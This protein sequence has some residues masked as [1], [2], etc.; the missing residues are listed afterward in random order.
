MIEPQEHDAAVEVGVAAFRA[1][2]EPP[3]DEQVRQR[4]AGAGV[5]PWLAER[6]L[7]FL[8]VAYTRRLLSDVSFTGTLLAPGGRVHLAEEP[9]FAA[10]LAR[11]Q[12]AGR[13]EIERIALRSGEFDAINNA[14][15]S[16][17]K[18]ADLELGE[19]TL[20]GDLPPAGPGDGGVP[21][22]RAAFQELLREHGVADRTG[23]D[24]RIFPHPAPPGV[25]MAQVDFTVTHP[26]LAGPRLV[27]SFAGHGPT[28]RD[29]LGRA[30][31]LFAGGA[32]HPI[33]DGLLRPGAAAGQVTRERYDHPD[34]PFDLV[35]GPWITLFTD[36]EVPGTRALLDQLLAALRAEPLTRQV[37]ALRLFSAHH[38]GR[39]QSSEVLVDSEPWAAG[40]ALVASQAA[41][42][43]GRVAV[44]V[45]G[46]L[47]PVPGH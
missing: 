29:A 8:P 19:P 26:A 13:G 33:V 10:A 46:L 9:V 45:F 20:T 14:L 37:H 42:L 21:S 17:S 41:P 11:A 30:L 2:D 22:P 35:L 3:S 7:L 40:E 36:E 16:G 6:L 24:A 38:D 4:L 43:P 5:E 1:G 23:A 12:R 32:L 34:G 15:Q 25:V 47:V 31:N 18:L 39:L 27:E 28:W 44:R